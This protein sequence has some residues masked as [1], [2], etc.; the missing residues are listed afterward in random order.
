MNPDRRQYHDVKEVRRVGGKGSGTKVGKG[1]KK[2]GQSPL[3]AVS[4]FGGNN[5]D[6]QSHFLQ[7]L[8]FFL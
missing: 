1:G 2:D 4:P 3:F 6:F 8:P 5:F 7:F